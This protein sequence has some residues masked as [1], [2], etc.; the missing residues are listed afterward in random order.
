MHSSNSQR[1]K[2]L[3][4]ILLDIEEEIDP[5]VR[6]EHKSEVG[7]VGG[8]FHFVLIV[9]NPHMFSM[10]HQQIWLLI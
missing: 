4:N 2:S 3:A 1:A 5:S 10:Q 7:I 6:E 9:R 8:I